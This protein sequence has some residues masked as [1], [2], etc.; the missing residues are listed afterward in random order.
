MRGCWP[1]GI[2]ARALRA[3]HHDGGDDLDSRGEDGADRVAENPTG[4]NQ[5]RVS[6]DNPLLLLFAVV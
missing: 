2:L 6:Q 4:E 1:D 3:R 5:N